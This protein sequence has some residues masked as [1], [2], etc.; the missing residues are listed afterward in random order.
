MKSATI[1]TETSLCM[2]IPLQTSS[3]LSHNLANLRYPYVNT[4][5]VR[6]NSWASRNLWYSHPW[7]VRTIYDVPRWML[8]YLLPDPIALAIQ[9][10]RRCSISSTEFYLLSSPVPIFLSLLFHSLRDLLPSLHFSTVTTLP[11]LHV[12]ILHSCSL[13]SKCSS[14]LI[15][16]PPKYCL[17]CYPTILSS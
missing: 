7:C 5:Q 15:S 13:A 9:E 3:P 6:L 2:E 14:V 11:T 4:L 17:C 10:T 8:S 1:V 16:F 12:S